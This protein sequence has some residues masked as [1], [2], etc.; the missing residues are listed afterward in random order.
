MKRLQVEQL[1]LFVLKYVEQ[2]FGVLYFNEDHAIYVILNNFLRPPILVNLTELVTAELVQSFHL[3]T[4][5]LGI[6]CSL[7]PQPLIR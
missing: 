6:V 5:Q 3:V 1:G 7:S 2:E 4:V